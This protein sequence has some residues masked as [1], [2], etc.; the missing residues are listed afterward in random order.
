MTARLVLVCDV[1]GAVTDDHYAHPVADARFRARATG[2][3]R[4]RHVRK[5]GDRLFAD[6]CPEHTYHLGFLTEPIVG[7]WK[8]IRPTQPEGPMPLAP[9]TVVERNFE[10]IRVTYQDGSGPYRLY[11]TLAAALRAAG[12]GRGTLEQVRRE[13]FAPGAD[14]LRTAER[15]AKV[16]TEEPDGEVQGDDGEGAT[17]EP[18]S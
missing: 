12:A 16:E 13:M 3:T 4:R 9:V 10:D 8:R 15:W 6:L 11:T 5:N 17:G 14:F 2:W 7:K 1:C 18:G